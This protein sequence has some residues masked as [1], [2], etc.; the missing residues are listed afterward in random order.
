[1][2]TPACSSRI[3]CECDSR[4]KLPLG[5]LPSADYPAAA[6]ACVRCGSLAWSTPTAPAQEDSASS[7]SLSTRA[8]LTPESFT[9][10]NRWPRLLATA[11]GDF[12]CLPAAVRC[13]TLF[14]L[15]VVRN[16]AW[17]AQRHLPRGRRL[18]RAGWPVTPPPNSL[19]S[20]LSHYRILWEAASFTAATN[21]DT[22]LYWADPAHSLVSPIALDRLLQRRDLR[23]LL[24]G[25]AHSP[26]LRRRVVLCA[27]A[28]EDASLIPLLRPHVQ[29]WLQRHERAPDSAQKRAFSSEAEIC[30]A[31]LNA[32]E[33]ARAFAQDAASPI[34]RAHLTAA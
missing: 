14:E 17:N 32:W 7:G 2:N 25:L 28:Q 31:S 16:A 23:A 15:E 30:R 24:P 27:L 11:N 26:V 6:T 12:A 21:L 8:T 33:L 18:N 13:T 9:W 20:S 5:V 34:H 1:M 4:F 29:S 22:L 3:G 19:P 10:L